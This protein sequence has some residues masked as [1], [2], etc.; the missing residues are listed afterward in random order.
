M[1]Q[2]LLSKRKSRMLRQWLWWHRISVKSPAVPR[3]DENLAIG[4]F[5]AEVPVDPLAEGNNLVMHATGAENGEL[6]VRVGASML[7]AVRGVQNLQIYYVVILRERGAAYYASSVTGANGLGAY[8][9]MRLLAIDAFGEEPSLYAGIHQATLGQIGFRLDT[10]IYG[11]R[12]VDVPEWG[13]WYGTAHA[14]DSLDGSGVLAGSVAETGGAWQ[15]IT[16]GFERTVEG[17][18]ANEDHSLALLLPSQRS[19]LVHVVIGGGSNDARAAGLVW[20]HLDTG[21]YWQLL[22]SATGCEL[23]LRLAGQF[24]M[25]ARSDSVR[26]E[27]KKS[28]S[29][30]VVDEGHRFGVFLDGVLLFGTRFA[31]ERLSLAAGVGIVVPSKESGVRLTLFEAHP[32]ECWM[33]TSLDQGRPWWR[34]G[35]EDIVTDSF[36][37]PAGDLDGKPT[38]TGAR[39]WRRMMGLGHIDVTGLGSAKV[40]ASAAQA[41][42]G[43]LAYAVDWNHPEFADL[44]V[45]ITPPGSVRG[46]GEQGRAGLLFWQDEANFILVNNW[47]QDGYGGASV[48]CFSC[49]GGFEDLYDAVWSNVGARIYWGVTHRFRVVFDGMHFLALVDDEPVLY[50]ALTDIYSDASRL[51]I[52]RVGLVANWEWGTDTGSSF[53]NFRA[54]T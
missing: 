34:L 14:A 46:Q 52:R 2:W 16:G 42:P 7:P 43:R 3:M 4:W 21:N 32:L 22:V 13:K 47:L 51:R 36:E 54:R 19:G 44:E 18:L 35:L 31:D 29:L 10:R 37:G 50:R 8:P 28:Q 9:N 25:I 33:P 5:P 53:R 26:L 15:Q 39:L 6:W 24:S 17:I 45:E 23:M 12:V 30:Q 41:C 38:T 20:R 48:S 1:L 27:L 49:Q 40:R 11:N